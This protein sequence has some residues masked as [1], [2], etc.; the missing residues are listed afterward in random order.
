VLMISGADDPATPPWLGAS[1]LPYLANA[2]RILVPGGHNN[3][4]A[5][6]DSIAFLNDPRPRAIH[7]S[8]AAEDKRPPFVTDLSSWLGPNG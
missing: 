2:R 5:C 4:T 6:L 3:A 7:A 1:Q 8:C